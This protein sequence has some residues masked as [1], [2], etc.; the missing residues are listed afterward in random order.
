MAFFMLFRQKSRI[1]ENSAKTEFKQTRIFPREMTWRWKSKM[2]KVPI[3]SGTPFLIENGSCQV[4]KKKKRK[5]DLNNN[6]SIVETPSFYFVDDIPKGYLRPFLMP[7]KLI[8]E[9]SYFFKR[10]EESYDADFGG[11]HRSIWVKNGQKL[12]R[13]W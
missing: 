2:K 4:P 13:K 7:A 6:K 10:S 11:V 3:D 12:V 9:V 8:H 5:I 1:H